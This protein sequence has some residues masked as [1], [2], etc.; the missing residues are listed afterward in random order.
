MRTFTS[1]IVVASF[2]LTP[3]S[4]AQIPNDPAIEACRTTGLIALKERS[5]SLKRLNLRHGIAG[6]IESQ[7][8]G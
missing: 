1:A 8:S 2:L 4:H 7:H 5:P 3:P 6:R